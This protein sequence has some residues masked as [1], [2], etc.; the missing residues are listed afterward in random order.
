MTTHE[1]ARKLLVFYLPK[2]WPLERLKCVADFPLG[3]FLVVPLS[4]TKHEQYTRAPP[5]TRERLPAGGPA[6]GEFDGPRRVHR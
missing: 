2:C 1:L 6:G 3:L 5:S 4:S